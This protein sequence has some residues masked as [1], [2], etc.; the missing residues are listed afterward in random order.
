MMVS[1]I[2]TARVRNRGAI[3]VFWRNEFPVQCP[4]DCSR[5]DIINQWFKQWGDEYEPFCIEYI[6]KRTLVYTDGNPFP[7]IV[8][9][10]I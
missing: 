5:D 2:V 1:Y 3:G 4:E 8:Y 9:V 7:D 10:R 6:D